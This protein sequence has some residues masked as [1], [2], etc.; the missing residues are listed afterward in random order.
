MTILQ[1]LREE[2]MFQATQYSRFSEPVA[3]IMD[4]LETGEE[5]IINVEDSHDFDIEISKPIS[6][7]I[8]YLM[9]HEGY[10][11][12]QALTLISDFINR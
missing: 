6:C 2:T 8:E 5:P 11:R 3:P 10:T 12:E 4:P 9:D 7:A 1:R